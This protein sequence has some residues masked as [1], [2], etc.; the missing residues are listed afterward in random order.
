MKM[1]KKRNNT[2]TKRTERF[3]LDDNT[4]TGVRKIPFLLL[5]AYRDV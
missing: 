5:C 3:S 4:G 2:A 1:K